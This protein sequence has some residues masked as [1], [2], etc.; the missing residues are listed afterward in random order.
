MALTLIPMLLSVQRENI[1]YT[2]NLGNTTHNYAVV[3][4]CVNIMFLCLAERPIVYAKDIIIANLPPSVDLHDIIRLT[5]RLALNPIHISPIETTGI[6][7]N[8]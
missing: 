6:K 4:I 5:K 7:Y 2:M 8:M 1:R 3:F